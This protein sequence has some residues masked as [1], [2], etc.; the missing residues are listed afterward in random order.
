MSTATSQLGTAFQEKQC[1]IIA[2]SMASDTRY[3]F[4]ADIVSRRGSSI[5]QLQRFIEN[6]DITEYK[7]IIILV[8][9]NDLSDKKVWWDYKKHKGS[10]DF[11]LQAH[12]TT[13]LDTLKT[14]Y[15]NLL[16]AVEIGNP[17]ILIE[18]QPIIPRLFDYQINLS[19]MK[20]VNNMI[21]DLCITRHHYHDRTLITSFLKGGK[22]DP[23]LYASDG[24]HLSTIGSDKLTRI[25]RTKVAK[26]IQKLAPANDDQ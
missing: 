15:I 22:P 3:I 17:G 6:L 21:K 8:G 26:L 24:L 10:P 18:L 19:Y 12:P 14:R 16:N 5:V 23:S 4:R 2:D 11:K 25:F 7:C 13:K 20:A 9:T 1:L